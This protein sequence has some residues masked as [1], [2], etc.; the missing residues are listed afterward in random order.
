VE[1]PNTYTLLALL[2]TT[3]EVKKSLHNFS[4]WLAAWL[5]AR[6]IRAMSCFDK[7]DQHTVSTWKLYAGLELFLWKV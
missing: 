5:F 7:K 2:I 4:A 6:E 3:F 1:T